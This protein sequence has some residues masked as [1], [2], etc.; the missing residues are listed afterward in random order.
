MWKGKQKEEIK[1]RPELLNS[2]EI[3]GLLKNSIT[4]MLMRNFKNKIYKRAECQDFSEV[5]T[6]GI[7]YVTLLYIIDIL[8]ITI[9]LHKYLFIFQQGIKTIQKS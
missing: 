7:V 1:F 9:L 3:A 6:P 4:I 5:W 2:T 8:I